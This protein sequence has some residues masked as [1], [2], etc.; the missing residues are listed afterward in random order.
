MRVTLQCPSRYGSQSRCFGSCVRP[1]PIQV[2]R[3]TP[4][5]RPALLRQLERE[6]DLAL[7]FNVERT[8]GSAVF[9]ESAGFD[10]A[11][12]SATFRVLVRG[13]LAAVRDAM[14]PLPRRQRFREPI[15][16]SVI[17]AAF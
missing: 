10:V 11:V 17:R 2:L 16:V 5:D 9:L 4:G 14:A 6:T 15:E 3:V 12:T 1:R 8:N 7:V 13:A